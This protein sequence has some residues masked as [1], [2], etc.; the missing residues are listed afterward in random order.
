MQNI[1]FVMMSVIHY[2]ADKDLFKQFYLIINVTTE[3]IILEINVDIYYQ[4]PIN[5]KILEVMLS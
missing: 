2:F 4:F 1:I 3:K 5:L